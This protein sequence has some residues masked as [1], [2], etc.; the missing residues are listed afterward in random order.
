MRDSRRG[1]QREKRKPK[2][3]FIFFFS[4]SGGLASAFDSG[5]LWINM[6]SAL[7]GSF[8]TISAD[9]AKGH[10]LWYNREK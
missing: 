10:Y 2:E 3:L 5:L 7:S 6:H 8:E 9:E 4:L 1:V